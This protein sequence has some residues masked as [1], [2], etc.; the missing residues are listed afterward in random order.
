MEPILRQV[1]WYP[2]PMQLRPLKAVASFSKS[3]WEVTE[4]VN[5]ENIGVGLAVIKTSSKP[6]ALEACKN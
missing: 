1:T 4:R 6:G 5:F 2:N 3:I